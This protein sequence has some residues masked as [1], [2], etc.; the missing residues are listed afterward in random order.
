MYRLLF[1]DEE[2]DDIDDFKDYIEEKDLDGV[3]EVIAI[4]PLEDLETMM[5]KVMSLHPD[6][7]VTD[8]MLNEIKTSIT[9]NVPY[10][11]TELISAISSQR[12]NFPCFVMTSFDDR[13][14]GESE[15]VNTVYIK[16]ILHGT[17]KETKAKANFLDRIKN[18]IIHY[19][20]KI[21]NAEKRLLEL[22][23]KNKT[24]K[25]SAPEEEELIDLD[26][27]IERALDK[28][29]KVTKIAK[30]GVESESLKELLAEVDALVK[31]LK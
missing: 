10:T 2:K 4:N 18:Q 11:G 20:A 21:E 14:V 12:E 16:G 25:L 27:I 1:I 9:Y 28:R 13:A 3:F 24:E 6:A 29:F 8:F 26:S 22:I 17:E 15:D 5:E 19:R 30:Q 31:K 23:E 7:V